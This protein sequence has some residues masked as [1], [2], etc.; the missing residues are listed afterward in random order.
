MSR[1]SGVRR[2]FSRSIIRKLIS[3]VVL[4]ILV[5]VAV[6]MILIAQRLQQLTTENIES[7]IV[8]LV[9]TNAANMDRVL[10]QIEAF[11]QV[12]A[13]IMEIAAAPNEDQIQR[14]L[15]QTLVANP[16]VFGATVAYEPFLFDPRLRLYSP[17]AYRQG[18]HIAFTDLGNIQTGSGYDYTDGN[19]E[20]WSLPRRNFSGTWTKPYFDK[21]GGNV[22]MV[23]YG[24]PFYRNT[25]FTGL[26]TVDVQIDSMFEL[27]GSVEGGFNALLTM[28]GGYIYNANRQATVESLFERENDYLPGTIDSFLQAVREN[29][30]GVFRFVRA[31]SPR[32][33]ALVP[34][35]VLWTVYARIPATD[36]IYQYYTGESQI[37]AP[38]LEQR[39]VLQLMFSIFAI[40]TVSLLLL[41]SR[42][43]VRPIT[44]LGEAAEKVAHGDY[45]V[46]IKPSS[47]DEL[48]RLSIV[49]NRMAQSLKNH[50]EEL[51]EKVELR[52][53]EL[54]E[55][56][57]KLS[58]QNELLQQR[59]VELDE[60]RTTTLK[61]M[62]EANRARTKLA[63]QNSLLQTFIDTNPYP[64]FFRD[65]EERYIGVNSAFAKAFGVDK[66]KIIGQKPGRKFIPK[67]H[68]PLFDKAFKAATQDGEITRQEISLPY[69]D[70]EIHESIY[71]LSPIRAS[72]GKIT[73]TLGALV[74]ISEQKR[75]E[76]KLK[77]AQ[78]KAE[79][80]TE[81]K[82]YFLATM[83]HEI[84]TPMNGVLGMVD[85]LRHTSLDEEQ[86]QMLRTIQDSGQALLTIINDILDI[87]KI[88]T[89]KLE[90]ESTEFSIRDVIESTAETLAG[91][92]AR[93]D[94]CLYTYSD[95]AIA[96]PL[97]GDP[98]RLRQVVL[99]L[100][101]NAIK[102]S[103]HG[104]IE[105]FATIEKSTEPDEV[106]VRVAVR[107]H[108][109]GISE[110]AQSKL[111]VPF[112]QAESSTT[113]KF[114]GTGLGLSICQRLIEIMGGTIGVNS[115]TGEGSEFYFTVSLDKVESAK[116]EQ[117]PV[118]PENVRVVLLSQRA[119]E[120]Q[121]C[122]DTMS[123]YGCEFQAFRDLEQLTTELRNTGNTPPRL[124]LIGSSWN[125][126]AQQEIRASIQALP[127][128]SEVR[129][130][131]L[132]LTNRVTPTLIDQQAVVLPVNPLKQ[133][134]LNI[135]LQFALDQNPSEL[136][137]RR[138]PTT[139]ATAQ[140]ITV[141]QA[142][143]NNCLI[144]VVE[145]NA[146]NR[147]VIS[148]QLR[149]LVY[150]CET[151]EDGELAYAAWRRGRYALLLSDIN[152]P[153][154]DGM[155]LTT[156][157]REEEARTA[158]KP[159][160]PVIALTANALKGDQERYLAIGMDGY[161]SKPLNI[162]DL[163]AVLRK[164]M[165][166]YDP[167]QPV[168][169]PLKATDEADSL[170]GNGSSAVDVSALTG[171]FGND[172]T[173]VKE[174][175]EDFVS[176]SQDIMKEFEQGLAANSADA[177]QKAA[178]KLK[179]AARTIGANEL[180]DLCEEAEIAGKDGDLAPVKDRWP[181]M[182]Q[183]MKDVVSYIKAMG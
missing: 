95:P 108:G 140:E 121:V 86:R 79:A 132:Q 33:D 90:L 153:N 148:R 88:G 122:Q 9:K 52:T 76:E 25:E 14:L 152:M 174:I 85:L 1:I 16:M 111:F 44:V 22:R 32:P 180:A 168:Q 179:S 5:T 97:L 138:A 84:R 131:L 36:W 134:Y 156:S 71:Y 175:L 164:W 101:G 50:R 12:N 49:F 150:A 29:G 82:A 46:D 41:M 167:Q 133:K 145:D 127:G 169:A 63:N 137:A 139:L 53:R 130:A 74:D 21:G 38:V 28:D 4:P 112:S 26:A 60:A 61:M 142:L 91:T 160:I 136:S 114:G 119:A 20:W 89:G 172:M 157:I 66:E 65:M 70:G 19:W 92:A 176:P 77:V 182:K 39:R 58:E 73:G 100:V 17:F 40:I 118:V 166:H 75:T 162:E 67:E 18:D 155:E 105:I 116:P 120:I 149:L 141:K 158:G 43:L 102:F 163:A 126:Q 117:A 31:S 183:A 8:N 80:A 125:E 147:D 3:F 7:N 59:V 81:A 72:D 24:T 146:T 35:P 123:Y 37:L 128:W 115:V 154:M 171:I 42:I 109:I 129:I 170:V 144:L 159:H 161:L 62:Q 48:G 51:E 34:E 107:D 181:N 68:I 10:S 64:L 27:M 98:L 13:S 23:S 30:S 54:T 69:M 47:Q 135:S 106:K 96:E 87:S 103:D 45:D 83:S 178:H 173:V 11:A 113:R 143:E 93:K 6:I 124:I 165:P 110:E 57:E 151:A 94:L 177:V 55:V 15:Q 104:E 78:Q 99:N 56:Q 2:Y